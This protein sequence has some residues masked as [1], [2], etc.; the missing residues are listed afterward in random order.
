MKGFAFFY[1]F[2]V[3]RDFALRPRAASPSLSLK[4]LRRPLGQ[5]QRSV[6]LNDQKMLRRLMH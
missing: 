4:T 3:L 6:F 1:S 5:R 2:F